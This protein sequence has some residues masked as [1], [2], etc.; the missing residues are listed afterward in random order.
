MSE[1]K[2][3]YKEQGCYAYCFQNI[4][5]CFHGLP[6]YKLCIPIVAFTLLGCMLKIT[7]CFS[8]NL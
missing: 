4:M 1:M 8:F 3:C 7:G 6:M 2:S 5:I